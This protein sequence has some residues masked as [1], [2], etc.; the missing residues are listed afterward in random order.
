[1]RKQRETDAGFAGKVVL[2]TGAASGLGRAMA[3]AF[4]EAGSDLVIADVNEPGLKETAGMVEATG[5]RCVQR[6]VD[7]SSREQME[8]MAG[9]V[10]DEF[11]RVDILVNNAGVA[12]GGELADIPIDDLEWIM[13]INLMGEM[14][15]T[16][17]FL[18]GMLERGRGHIVNVSSVSG[19]VVLPFHIPYTTTKFGVAGM[20]EALRVEAGCHGVGVTLVCPGAI[21]TGIM[22][23][24]RLHGP[25]PVRDKAGGWWTRL[26]AG[27]GSEPEDVARRVLDAV[28][29]NRF[30]LLTGLEAHLLYHLRRLF[31]GL[32]RR[33]AVVATRLMS[34]EA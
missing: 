19:F 2:V 8:E 23:N 30:L 18:P 21:R 33:L 31:P 22:S 4:A 13:G 29:D 5:G 16:R 28:R 3:V 14:Y 1:M 9:A 26:L 17:L 11:G 15:G 34:R 25:D 7:V 6:R 20:T 24:A 12:V 27:R 10:L 32:A